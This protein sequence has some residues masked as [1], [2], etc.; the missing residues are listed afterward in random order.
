MVVFTG[1]EPLLQLDEALIEACTQRGIYAAVET[2][3]TKPIPQGLDWGV[4]FTETTKYDCRHN[5]FRT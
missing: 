4:C 5:G 3:G 2:N 1:G